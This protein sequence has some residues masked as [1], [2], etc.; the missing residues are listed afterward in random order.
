MTYVLAVFFFFLM[1]ASVSAQSGALLLERIGEHATAGRE[2]APYATMSVNASP[3]S[4]TNPQLF[5]ALPSGVHTIT[6]ADVIGLDERVGTCTYPIGTAE[7]AVP[8]YSLVP[9][10]TVLGCFLSLPVVSGH[11]TKVSVKYAGHY[12]GWGKD[13]VGG[14]NGVVVAVT[15]LNASG[16]GSLMA[17]LSSGSHRY[18]VFRVAGTISFSTNVNAYDNINI[19]KPFQT[20][21]GFTAPP[22]GITIR[23]AALDLENS[24]QTSA[25]LGVRDIIVRGMRFRKTNGAA[26][27]WSAAIKRGY[28]CCKTASTPPIF[29]VVLDH[30][31]FSGAS[32]DALLV[33]D[34]TYNVTISW[35]TINGTVGS[36]QNLLVEGRAKQISIHHCFLGLPGWRNPSVVHHGALDGRSETDTINADIRNTLVHFNKTS[37]NYEGIAAWRGA[38]LNAIN[39]YFLGGEG[40]TSALMGYAITVCGIN[41][42][43]LWN[44]AELPNARPTLAYFSGNIIRPTP[45]TDL[46]ITRRMPATAQEI[47]VPAVH[48]TGAAIAACQVV[49]EAGVWPL[50]AHDQPYY[51]LAKQDL[52]V[53]EKCDSKPLIPLSPTHL[54]IQ[55][56]NR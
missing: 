34:L 32:D 33:D 49:R 53:Y 12:E 14:K 2:T 28:S 25:N 19:T 1:G 46:N 4:A 6:V 36:K 31:A 3:P 45:S 11:V 8:E 30:L 42:Q 52:A 18:I 35:V 7:C 24:D 56:I 16:P 5:S 22:P 27:Q 26:S 21:D 44:G 47:P 20:I 50:D 41:H 39:N 43:C 51:T 17:A 9:S 55:E 54:Q 13:T 15:N 37:Q 48:M 38:K 10:C 29:N 23:E 40:S